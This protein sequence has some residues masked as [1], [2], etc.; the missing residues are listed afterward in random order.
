MINRSEWERHATERIRRKKKGTI[1]STQKRNILLQAG[2]NRRHHEYQINIFFSVL[3]LIL[4]ACIVILVSKTTVSIKN[5]KLL[6]TL[7]KLELCMMVQ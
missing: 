5:K 3:F 6:Y 2:Q 4:E 1:K 7:Y